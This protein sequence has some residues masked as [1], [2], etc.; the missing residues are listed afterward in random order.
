MAPGVTKVEIKI[1]K[2]TN[3]NVVPKISTPAV[4]VTFEVPTAKVGERVATTGVKEG[5]VV[6]NASGQAL[7]AVLNQAPGKRGELIWRAATTDEIK[8][9]EEGNRL[10]LE[11]KWS[12]PEPMNVVPIMGD[13]FVAPDNTVNLRGPSRATAVGVVGPLVEFVA[14]QFGVTFSAEKHKQIAENHR[15]LEFWLGLSTQEV[16]NGVYDGFVRNGTAKVM[17]LAPKVE[18][19]VS[20][21]YRTGTTTQEFAQQQQMMDLVFTAKELGIEPELVAEVVLAHVARKEVGGQKVEIRTSAVEDIKGAME[22]SRGQSLNAV[23]SKAAFLA[24]LDPKVAEHY[25]T[26]MNQNGDFYFTSGDIHMYRDFQILSNYVEMNGYPE[27][28]NLLHDRA[29]LRAFL[30]LTQPT[31]VE[32]LTEAF[33][34]FGIPEERLKGQE[35]EIAE[36]WKTSVEGDPLSMRDIEVMNPTEEWAPVDTLVEESLLLEDA[37]I[38]G[39][40]DDIA[41]FNPFDTVAIPNVEKVAGLTYRLE[42]WGEYQ[43]SLK[44]SP[45]ALSKQYMEINEQRMREIRN[46]IARLDPQGII[47]NSRPEDLLNDRFQSL[48]DA[49]VRQQIEQET[50]YLNQG[51][52]TVVDTNLDTPDNWSSFGLK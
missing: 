9:A 3:V 40:Q 47:S 17:E 2:P 16:N 27:P 22:R 46:E 6:R 50:A 23:E 44:Q 4:K 31:S 49:E 26:E 18:V 11:N 34:A 45:N 35:G 39:V 42:K 14:A 48:L 12:K 41:G 1:V 10:D 15:K 5:R 38:L 13:T 21:I 52:D 7:I 24:M 30:D 37:D 25:L 43:E 29:A 28:M 36:I 33:R 51:Q 8:R 20:E 19:M 32:G